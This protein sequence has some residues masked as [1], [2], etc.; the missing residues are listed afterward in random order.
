M[1]CWY[2]IFFEKVLGF[3]TIKEESSVEV[4]EVIDLRHDEVF[5]ANRG[6]IHSYYTTVTYENMSYETQIKKEIFE[7]IKVGDYIECKV[8]KREKRNSYNSTNILINN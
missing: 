8:V 6:I 3:E 7:Q 1:L 4:L 2:D 5:I